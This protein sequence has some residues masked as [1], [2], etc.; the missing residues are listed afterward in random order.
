MNEKS[1]RQI[2]L[3]ILSLIFIGFY[4]YLVGGEIDFIRQELKGN[5]DDYFRI[6]GLTGYYAEDI[7]LYSVFFIIAGNAVVLAVFF[8]RV[9]LIISVIV[10][11]HSIMS[12]IANHHGSPFN[13]IGQLIVLNLPFSLYNINRFILIEKR[14]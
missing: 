4:L 9:Y 10:L 12:I 2:S 8:K 11:F 6:Y 3:I 5:V 7:V 13:Y 14:T 1:M